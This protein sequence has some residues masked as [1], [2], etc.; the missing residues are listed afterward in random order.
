MKLCA[1]P[2]GRQS[3]A[4]FKALARL[5]DK[6]TSSVCYSGLPFGTALKGSADCAG[7]FLFHENNL[8]AC[9]RSPPA[10]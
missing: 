6:R 4:S 1:A 5:P 8:I 2:V 10:I 7:E 9:Y 3:A